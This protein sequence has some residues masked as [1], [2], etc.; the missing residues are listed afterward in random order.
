MK[1]GG[2]APPFLIPALDGRE[3]SASRSG[4]FTPGE[5]A[6]GPGWTLRRENLLPLPEIEP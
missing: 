4:R 1:G 5:R 6:P 2:I 3:L